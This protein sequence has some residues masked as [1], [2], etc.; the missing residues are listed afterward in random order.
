MNSRRFMISP[1]SQRAWLLQVMINHAIRCPMTHR[2]NRKRRIGR[3]VLREGRRAHDKEIGH[4]PML[5][6]GVHNALI[7][8]AS[9][10]RPSL[11]VRSDVLG[12]VVATKGPTCSTRVGLD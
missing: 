2:N 1:L 4:L 5:Q 12:G 10:D 6:P 3:R 9:H 7:R 11:Y 8:R